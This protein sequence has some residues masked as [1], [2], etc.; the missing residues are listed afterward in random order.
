MAEPTFEW[1]VALAFGGILV[2]AS[3]PLTRAYLVERRGRQQRAA[4]Q[5]LGHPDQLAASIEL[6]IDDLLDEPDP[7]RAVIAAY[8]RMET[9]FA[10]AG[11]TRPENET[12]REYLRRLVVRMTGDAEDA[13]RLTILFERAKFGGGDVTSLMKKTAVATL[14]QIRNDLLAPRGLHPR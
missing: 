1:P 14:R 13:A 12:P 7:R 6:V 5:K 9:L 2:I 10:Q 4:E 3:V 11:V 8:A